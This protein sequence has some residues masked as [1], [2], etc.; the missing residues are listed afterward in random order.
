VDIAFILT[1]RKSLDTNIRE[2]IDKFIHLKDVLGI[3]HCLK[4]MS[5][6][7]HDIPE[8]DPPREKL[9]RKGAAALSD[10]ELLHYRYA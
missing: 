10:Q 2:D 1:D 8:A 5:K 7:I 4:P 3:A 6:S 9:L